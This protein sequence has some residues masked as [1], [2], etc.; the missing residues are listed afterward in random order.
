MS[1]DDVGQA[2]SRLV[3]SHMSNIM[4]YN[5][6]GPLTIKILAPLSMVEC[7]GEVSYASSSGVDVD[8]YVK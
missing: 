1:D 8:R 7:P 6:F 2:G 5:A 3:S 4:M